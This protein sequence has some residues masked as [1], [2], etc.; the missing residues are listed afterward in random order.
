MSVTT[1]YMYR[2]KVHKIDPLA[3][4]MLNPTGLNFLKYKKTAT[5]ITSLTDILRSAIEHFFELPTTNIS[6]YKS[7]TKPSY[8]SKCPRIV[9][10]WHG[11]VRLN[12]RT[13][14]PSTFK[15]PVPLPANRKSSW[16]IISNCNH[17]LYFFFSQ[18][19]H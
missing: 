7:F 12:D 10:I 11:Q 17:I 18:S 6:N 16:I 9:Q 2:N 1:K 19:Q 15:W 8:F 5:G 13:L 4:M 3:L 14:I